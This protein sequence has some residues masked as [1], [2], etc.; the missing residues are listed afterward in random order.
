M[1]VMVEK[2]FLHQSRQNNFFTILWSK[3]VYVLDR[4]HIIEM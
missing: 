4:V 1:V 3:Y 2:T